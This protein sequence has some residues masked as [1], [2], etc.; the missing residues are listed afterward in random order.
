MGK[1]KTLTEHLRTLGKKGAQAQ[2]RNV[3]A[4]QLSEWGK[5]GARR[6]WAKK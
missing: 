2:K 5:K 3:S 6:R 4:K 1:P